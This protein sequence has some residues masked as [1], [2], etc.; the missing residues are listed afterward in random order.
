MG[1]HIGMGIAEVADWRL[2]KVWVVDDE[3]EAAA[4]PATT[5]LRAKMRTTSFMTLLLF[6]W[7]L[8]TEVITSA[9]VQILA[10][11]VS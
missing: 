6:E 4:A 10:Q 5:T 11:N 7:F 3:T 2:V 8:L 9:H 1:P